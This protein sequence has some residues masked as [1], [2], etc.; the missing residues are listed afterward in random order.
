MKKDTIKIILCLA[1]GA[2]LAFGAGVLFGLLRSRDTMQVLMHLSDGFFFSGAVIGGFG[3][4]KWARNKG[5]FD[6]M[7]YLA[8]KLFSK[9]KNKPVDYAGFRE[10]KS[11]VRTSARVPLIAGG[12]LV[13]LSLIL[14]ALYAA[15][16][17][18]MSWTQ[19][20]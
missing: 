3:L 19:A 18:N 6:G 15:A 20:A 14:L 1:F 9:D 10:E 11:A 4:M 17:G 12:A 2:A 13:A 5:Q 7:S 8:R 16:G